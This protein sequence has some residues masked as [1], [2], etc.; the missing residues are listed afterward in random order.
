AASLYPVLLP[1]LCKA[2]LM[3]TAEGKKGEQIWGLDERA[4]KL[5]RDGHGVRCERCGTG[6]FVADSEAT[7]WTG[8]T[9]LSSACTGRYA[10]DPEPSRDYF[11]RL[12]AS[13]DLQ[14]IFTAEHTGLLERK[15]REQV[16]IEFKAPPPGSDV[17]PSDARKPWYPNLL[18]C[19]PTLEMGI[20]IGD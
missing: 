13:G 2:G 19:T 15:A 11:G 5:T 10:T 6:M 8:M 17:D 14:R 18:S 1:G 7:Y 3:L 20:D 16:E 12:Y 9:C 4:L